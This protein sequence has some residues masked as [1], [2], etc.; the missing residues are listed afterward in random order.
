MYLSI[1]LRRMI[2]RYM[3]QFLLIRENLYFISLFSKSFHYYNN[4]LNMNLVF[5]S[6]LIFIC[7]HILSK[8]N[9]SSPIN[10]KEIELKNELM[11]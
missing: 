4:E 3:N 1:K 2:F 10:S 6:G 7:D 5:I 9:K 11:S 8:F